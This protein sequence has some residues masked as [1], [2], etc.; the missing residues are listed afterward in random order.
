[1]TS[2]LPTPP[3]NPVR[4]VAPVADPSMA[5]SQ[6][7]SSQFKAGVFKS[8]PSIVASGQTYSTD[9][10]ISSGGT[11]FLPADGISIMT[12]TSRVFDFTK[13]MRRVSIA[14]TEIAD[15]QVM[16]PYQ[17]NLVGHKP[18]FT[19]LAVWT[20][21]GNYE[22]RQ[23]RVDPGGKQQVMLHCMVAQ[24]DRNKIENQGMNIAAGLASAGV[25]V[26]GMPGAVGTPFSPTMPVMG[27][28]IFGPVSMQQQATMPVGGQLLPFLLSQ[29]VT[30]GMATQNG[31]WATN[32]FFQFLEN[33]GLGKIL[34][35]PNLLANS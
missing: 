22:E 21:Q 34:A 13:R 6:T 32:T 26:F 14:D 28:S 29:N 1:M 27:Q 11:H 23:V 18:G 20:T 8:D 19:T 12:G 30:Y 9:G 3:A 15:V 25:T 10:V 7:A 31:Q 2:A 4:A 17:L 24:L 16:S 33:H 5:P 35:Q